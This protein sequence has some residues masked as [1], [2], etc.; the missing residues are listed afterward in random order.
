MSMGLLG[1]SRATLCLRIKL[2]RC[3]HLYVQCEYV[4][5]ASAS[6]RVCEPHCV[7]LCHRHQRLRKRSEQPDVAAEKSHTPSYLLAVHQ[8]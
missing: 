2:R 8:F 1:D 4:R 7:R 6:A 3:A 5:A